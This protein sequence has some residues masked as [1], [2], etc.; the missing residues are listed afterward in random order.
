MSFSRRRLPHAYPEGKWL[1][2][3]WHLHG[4]LPHGLFPPPAKASAGEAFVW[5][6]RYL[7]RA[8]HGPLYLRQPEV[9]RIVIESLHKGVGL[10]H[11]ELGAFVVMANHVHVLLR[12]IIDASLLLR[13][14]KGSSAREANRFLGL[15]GRPFWQ[16]ETYDHWVRDV[17]EYARISAYI[18]NNP[19]KA[20]LVARPEDYLWSSAH[21]GGRLDTNV[22][23]AG[24][25]AC[26]TVGVAADGGR[27]GLA[28]WR[29]GD[30]GGVAPEAFEAVVFS[31]FRVEDMD[32]EVA[33]IA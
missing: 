21:S 1:F 6:D 32:Q 16:A 26:A 11:F 19:V 7:D 13:S 10:R 5:I 15:T 4:S 9:A 22:E 33:V 2:L 28:G 23:A 30:G 3:T 18:E 29:E 31:L 17:R 12:P 14:L 25:S 27:L 24:K 8:A 20:G